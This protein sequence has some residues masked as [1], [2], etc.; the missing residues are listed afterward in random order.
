MN[1]R[2]H[3]EWWLPS[4]VA[5]VIS[6]HSREPSTDHFDPSAHMEAYKHIPLH[7]PRLP[8]DQQLRASREFLSRMAE[9]RSVRS[10]SREPV[11]PN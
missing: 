10:F 8:A 6:L 4:S 3:S 1:G 2:A 5:G 9:R 7:F 11:P